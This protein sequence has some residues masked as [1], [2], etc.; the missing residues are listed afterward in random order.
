MSHRLLSDAI[1]LADPQSGRCTDSGN[2]YP[3]V[4]IS[5]PDTYTMTLR[6]WCKDWCAQVQPDKVI[7]IATQEGF[8][9]CFCYF[10]SD[11]PPADF[12]PTNDFLQKYEPDAGS[13][14]VGG[15]FTGTG[16]VA[17][18]NTDISGFK[19]YRNCAYKQ[20]VSIYACLS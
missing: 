11:D 17:G 10:S 8:N 3:L 15:S 2:M 14:T 4:G 6:D 18:T 16:C 9:E 12:G 7:A 5:N 13:V 20:C 19:C 1:V